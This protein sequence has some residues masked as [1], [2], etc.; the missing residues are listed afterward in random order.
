MVDK[1]KKLFKTSLIK[2][3]PSI[4]KR[5]LK[6]G[7]SRVPKDSH[8]FHLFCM[9]HEPAKIYLTQEHFDY[10]SDDFNKET[11][12]IFGQSLKHS[13]EFTLFLAEKEGK[14]IY[15]NT[16]VIIK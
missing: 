9:K 10:L 11:Y 6:V 15:I 2:G 7:D 4:R 5:V 1:Q 14:M 3:D 12:D 8:E 16:E 13:N